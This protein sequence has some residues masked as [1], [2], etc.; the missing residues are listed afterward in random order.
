MI[1]LISAGITYV[2]SL[3]NIVYQMYCDLFTQIALALLVRC[4]LRELILICDSFAN[5][6]L[7]WAC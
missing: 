1:N 6:M 4:R 5:A 2:M 3:Y 7:I